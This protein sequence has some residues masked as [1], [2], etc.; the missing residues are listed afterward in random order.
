[1][2]E[3]EAEP[4]SFGVYS[5]QFINHFSS[6][7]NTIYLCKIDCKIEKNTYKIVKNGVKAFFPGLKVKTLKLNKKFNKNEMEA[8][9]SE[10]FKKSIYS[11][12]K[13]LKFL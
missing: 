4:Q 11:A 1:M 8:Y 10:E 9:Y 6:D 3:N 12:P 2:Y 13:I 7:K 5:G